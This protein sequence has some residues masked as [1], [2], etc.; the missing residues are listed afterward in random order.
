MPLSQKI[1]EDLKQAMKAKNTSRISCLRLLKSALKNKQV[2]KRRELED[3]EIQTVISSLIR[4]G[5]EA[6]KEFRGGNRLDLAAKEEEEIKILYEYLP[7]Q[8][9]PADIEKNL[10][11]IISELSATSLKDLGNVMKAAMA[12]MAGK[13]QG[14][15]VNEIAKKLLS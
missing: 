1:I 10:K 15:E 14:K 8:L 13:A 7:E 11:E 3:E 12:R 2:E 4:K 9:T 5:Q 6:A